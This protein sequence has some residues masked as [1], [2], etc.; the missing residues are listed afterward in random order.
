M[1]T[2]VKYEKTKAFAAVNA[3]PLDGTT[4][5]ITFQPGDRLNS[6][7]LL[8]EE[9][10]DAVIIYISGTGSA[11]NSMVFSIYGYSLTGG[12][13]RI[14]KTATATLGSGVAGSGLLYADTITGTDFHTSPVGVFDSGNN[15]ICKIK[16]DTQGLNWLYFEPVT[17]T[18]MTACTFHVREVGQK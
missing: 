10:T 17:F 11:N 7:C 14:Y 1:S 18:T 3:A 13:E 9:G 8:L 16:F 5:G 6:A 4:A 2:L 12:A 15:T